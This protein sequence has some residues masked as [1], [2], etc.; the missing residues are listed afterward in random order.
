MQTDNWK[1]GDKI[2]NQYEIY[3][4]L[5]GGMGIV[6]VCYDHKNQNPVVLKTYQEKYFYSNERQKLFER[7]ALLWTELD[8]Y[9]YIVRAYWVEKIEG[10][11]FIV[12]EYIA[13]DKQGRNTLQNYLT[14]LSLS[15]TIKLSIQFCYGM[16]YAYSKGIKVHRDIKPQNIMITQDM[17]VKITD[18]G[19]A[20]AFDES[21]IKERDIN[22][23]I[24][25]NV[26]KTQ[27]GIRGGT[28]PYMAPEM[29]D[30]V[31]DVRSDIY[32]FGIVLFQMALNDEETYTAESVQE[33]EEYHKMAKT[34]ESS[35]PLTK[36]I[37]KSLEVDPANRYQ[38]FGELREELEK[39]LLHETGKSFIPLTAEKFSSWE[40]YNKGYSLASFDR[41]EEEI[42]CYNKAI[43]INPQN[44]EFWYNKGCA[45]INIKQYQEAIICFE[46]TIRISP[47]HV[48]AWINQGI[49][50]RYL[51]QYKEALKCYEMS[52]RLN[53]NQDVA[54]SNKG[55]VLDL[56]LK[57]DDAIVC[58]NEAIRINPRYADA[59]Y[60]KGVALKNL[61]RY[62]EAKTCYDESIRLQ[63]GHTDV[64]INRGNILTNLGKNE[65]AIKSYD[66]AISKTSNDP[67]ILSNK[68]VA[69]T[70]LGRYDEAIRCFDEA[71]S[72]NPNLDIVWS[73]KA[74]TLGKMSLYKDAIECYNQALKINPRH[75]GIL[76]N[77]GA[78]CF[79]LGQYNEAISCA[80][81]VLRINPNNSNAQKLKQLCLKQLG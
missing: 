40:W 11:L 53:P 63:S 21:E 54:W 56:L 67:E 79:K 25:L 39:L 71:I 28:L 14:T 51:S 4:I 19:L 22:N 72:I 47:S 81:Q 1:I 17:V 20:K 75:E 65:E 43:K 35:S 44:A 10:R 38:S 57:F 41:Y 69:L 77:K 2:A 27:H 58:F 13:P 68:G 66:E 61:G 3:K 74:S 62:E 15:E 52:I 6:Y 46:T 48:D 64:W 18:F 5:G 42:A 30:G 80:E 49:A 29:F 31:A 60:N 36:I 33:F 12:L 24:A 70:N 7:E 76:I 45:L 32:S 23:H 55:T 16:E 9:P 8:K 59:W 73:N 37:N 78:T 34:F 50:W 26:Y